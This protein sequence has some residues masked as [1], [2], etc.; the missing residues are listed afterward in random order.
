MAVVIEGPNLGGGGYDMEYDVWLLKQLAA[1]AASEETSSTGASVQQ[2]GDSSQSTA[3]IDQIVGKVGPMISKWDP[4]ASSR[5]I[6][7][8]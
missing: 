8:F 3:M 1:L 7:E 5:M 6:Q 2:F 4:E